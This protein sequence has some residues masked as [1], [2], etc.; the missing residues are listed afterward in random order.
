MSYGLL[1]RHSSIRRKSLRTESI[2]APKTFD[3]QEM[4]EKKCLGG[5]VYPR[6]NYNTLFF[7]LKNKESVK[8]SKCSKLE[9][10]EDFHPKNSSVERIFGSNGKS[11][12]ATLSRKRK[13]A[14][15]LFLFFSA[16]ASLFVLCLDRRCV[17]GS[18]IGT[19]RSAG[20][21]QKQHTTLG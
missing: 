4:N 13:I 15:G 7:S 20:N 10:A 2:M 12:P 19:G 16:A 6:I 9:K 5:G 21:S 17:E 18:E 11:N 1:Q 14:C 3:Y 8:E